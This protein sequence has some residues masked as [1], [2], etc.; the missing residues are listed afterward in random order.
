MRCG[1]PGPRVFPPTA[2][3]VEGQGW[4]QRATPS[5]W[6][7]SVTPYL[8]PGSA[9]SVKPE[10][11]LFWEQV[12]C[13]KGSGYLTD[14]PDS[15]YERLFFPTIIPEKPLQPFKE[16]ARSPSQYWMNIW[17]SMMLLTMDGLSVF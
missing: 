15:F 2:L 16:T 11:G 7:K 14:D 3:W 13:G 8:C 10:I 9:L 6:Q 17:R 1:L 4:V 12:F 5:Y